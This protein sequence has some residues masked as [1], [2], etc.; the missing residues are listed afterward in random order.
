MAIRICFEEKYVARTLDKSKKNDLA[1]I[2]PD[3]IDSK[4]IG[5]AVDKGVHVYGYLNACTL[6]KERWYYDMLKDLRI[7]PY[8]GWPG[9][10]WVDVTSERWKD[11]LIA[12]ARNMHVDGIKGLYFDNTDLYY[13]CLKGFGEEKTK[14]IKPAPRAWSVYTSL[15]DVM[16][17]ITAMG[18][19][20]MPNGGDDFVRKLVNNGHRD[21]VKTVIQESVLYSDNKRVSKKDTKYFTEYLDWCKKHGIYVRGIEYCKSAKDILYAK[22]YYLKHGWPGLYISKHHNLEGD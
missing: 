3:G 10:Y 20:V 17:R 12:A 14:M 6:E 18:M 11:H 4:I 16:Q 8:E 19:V 5:T 1:I 7:A 9:E 2:D 15:L 22:A 21:L 13:M